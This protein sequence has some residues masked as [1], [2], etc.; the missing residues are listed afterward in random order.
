MYLSKM[1]FMSTRNNNGLNAELK[2]HIRSF[3]VCI[4]GP[5]H[6]ASYT[7]GADKKR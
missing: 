2:D 7:V 1:N 6:S 3:H 5:Q 4:P